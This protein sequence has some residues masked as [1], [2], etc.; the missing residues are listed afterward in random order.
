MDKHGPHL[1]ASIRGYDSD[2]LFRQDLW[3][4]RI[5]DNRQ[6]LATMERSMCSEACEDQ[7]KQI[8]AEMEETKGKALKIAD[9]ITSGEILSCLT[10]DEVTEELIGLLN[11]LDAETQKKVMARICS[12]LDS[13]IE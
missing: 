1:S 4:R 5:A 3:L 12:F 13:L 9:L 10:V 11:K 2:E 8:C 6:K 7:A